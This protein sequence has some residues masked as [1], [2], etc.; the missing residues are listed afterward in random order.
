ME[1]TAKQME[2]IV[3]QITAEIIGGGASTPSDEIPVGVSNRHIH[4]TREHVEILFGKGY[5]R[6]NWRI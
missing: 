2:E 5:M 4:L 6:L 1:L 3:R